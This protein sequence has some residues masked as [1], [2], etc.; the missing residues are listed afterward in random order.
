MKKGTTG[1]GNRLATLRVERGLGQRELSNKSGVNIR[2]IQSFES[3]ERDIGNAA[4]KTALHLADA[5][6]VHP[7]ELIGE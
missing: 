2:Q 4:L 1:R 6:D 3:G 7:R 5:L